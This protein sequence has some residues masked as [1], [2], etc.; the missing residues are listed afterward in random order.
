LP[1]YRHQGI[2]G[3]SM[4]FLARFVRWTPGLLEQA[5]QLEQLRA[6][7]NGAR[8]RVIVTAHR[9]VGVDAPADV[10]AVEAQLH[11]GAHA[12]QGSGAAMAAVAD[13]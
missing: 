3:Y 10:A 1:Y 6:L 12:A 8:I 7:E 4:A 9:S 13:F 2:Y 5:E 11:A